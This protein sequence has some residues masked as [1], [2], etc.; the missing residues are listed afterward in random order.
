MPVHL[1]PA[2][3]LLLTVS[4]VAGGFGSSTQ[5]AEAAAAAAE[6]SALQAE[7]LFWASMKDSQNPE[8]LRAYLAAYPQGRFAALARARLN[9]L[10]GPSGEKPV[11]GAAP[12]DATAE[13]KAGE[14]LRDCDACPQLVVVPAGRFEMGSKKDGA[15]E[16]PAHEVIISQPFAIGIYEV[17]VAEWDHCA[18]EGA[19]RPSPAVESPG[20]LP[21]ANISWDDAKKF[22][23]WLS[24]KTGRTYRLPSEA[25]WE[26]AA[27]AGSTTRYWW[28]DDKGIKRANCTDCGSQW[29]GKAAAP[30]GS[31]EPNAF[32]L[33]DVHGNIWEWTEDCWNGNYR[34]APSDGGAWIRGDCISRVLRGGSWALDHAYMRSA[35]RSR[36]DRDVRYY[37]HGLRVLRELPPS[38]SAQQAETDAPFAVAVAKAAKTIFASAPKPVSGAQSL[39]L[40]PVVDGLSGTQSLAGRAMGEQLTGIIR[41]DYPQFQLAEFT[42]SAGP[43]P[44]VLIGTF[45]GVNKE[46]KPAGEREAFRVCLALL[47]LKSGKVV[48]KAKEFAQPVGVDVTPT[49]FYRDSPAWAADP[50][51]QTYIGTCQAT[52]L[53]APV[54][55]LYL[56]RIETAALINDAINAYETGQYDAS[57]SLFKTAAQMQ[58]GDQLRT[59]NGLYLTSWRLGERNEA[60]DVFRKILSY[61]LGVGRLG[62]KLPF[63]PGSAAFLPDTTGSGLAEIWLTEI[64]DEM[65][66]RQDCIEIQGHSRRSGPN[67]SEENLSLRR[68]EYVK[69]RLEAEAPDLGRRLTATGKGSADTL[70]GSG[71]GDARDAIDERIELRAVECPPKI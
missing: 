26:Y 56:N 57:Q 54:D 16:R 52:N 7:L 25:E 2:R 37:L 27:R 51:T 63:R 40:D 69:R 10:S 5:S 55:P 12:S 71:S 4:L 61:G 15:D 49:A 36:Y 6:D 11:T 29:D 66:R 67:D 20:N 35:R 22:V 38:A 34:G 13:A 64:A 31:F 45:T 8:E 28:G 21:I 9:T 14:V 46:R 30:V 43:Y 42:A 18:R 39:A 47:D 68:A 53:G 50:S 58:G 3:I 23:T 65:Q 19:C 60:A 48:S 44:Y 32:G 24:E 33:Y 41:S 17:T 70:V 62:I 1:S 59:L